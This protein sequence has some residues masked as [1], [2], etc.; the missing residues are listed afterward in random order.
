MGGGPGST[1]AAGPGKWG[2][3]NNENVAP[4][5]TAKAHGGGGV[6]PG[7]KTYDPESTNKVGRRRRRDTPTLSA[8]VWGCTAIILFWVQGKVTSL[9]SWFTELLILRQV[10]L[11]SPRLCSAKNLANR[12]AAQGSLVTPS[13][14]NLQLYRTTQSYVVSLN[15]PCHGAWS[16]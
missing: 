13:A 7:T 3:G 15:D 12:R 9:V 10:G 1:P 2:N 6:T 8:F 5:P 16:K 11:R 4:T 14:E